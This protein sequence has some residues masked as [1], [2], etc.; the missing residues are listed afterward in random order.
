MDKSNIDK[1]ISNELYKSYNFRY[2]IYVLGYYNEMEDSV[3]YYLILKVKSVF[4]LKKYF[5]TEIEK[6]YSNLFILRTWLCFC[7]IY[8][9]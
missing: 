4:I 9:Y 5:K 1:T 7:F 6:I 3:Y 8:T 2:I